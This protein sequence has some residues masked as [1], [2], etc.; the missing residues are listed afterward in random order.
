MGTWRIRVNSFDQAIAD[1]LDV[2]VIQGA[3]TQV[4]IASNFDEDFVNLLHLGFLSVRE[5]I[6]DLG[7]NSQVE[8]DKGSVVDF[9]VIVN[10]G[11]RA[12]FGFEAH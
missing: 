2:V 3:I 4:G 6:N 1:S 7:C 10:V 5:I 8:V 11:F 12:V 9:L